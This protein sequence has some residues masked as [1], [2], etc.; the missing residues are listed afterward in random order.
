MALHIYFRVYQDWH[1]HLL[2][3]CKEEQMHMYF[4]D[5]DPDSKFLKV[6]SDFGTSISNAVKAG[7]YPYL[8]CVY[9]VNLVPK[10]PC[11]IIFTKLGS[12][13][14]TYDHEKKILN[15]ESG[16][17]KRKK[18]NLTVTQNFEKSIFIANPTELSKNILH[19]Y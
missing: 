18:K 8:V 15:C 10:H 19:T 1:E 9:S 3:F 11:Q 2:A 13:V 7:K 6:C 14:S 16:V 17:E 12:T 5:R 4:F